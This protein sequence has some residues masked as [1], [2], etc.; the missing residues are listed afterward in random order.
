MSSSGKISETRAL[1]ATT[2]G[3]LLEVYDFVAYGIFA[4]P[5]SKAFFPADSESVSLLLTFL[6][7][8]SGFLVRPIGAL[9]LG[10]Y[11]DRCG[12]RKALSLTLGLMA[13]GTGILVI[14]PTYASIGMAAPMIVLAG[15]LIQG[16]SAGGEIGGAITLAIESV[17]PARRA[18]ASAVQQMAQGGGVLLTAL[19]GTA[20]SHFFTDAQVNDGA[21]RIVFAIGLLIVPVGI[22]IRR[23]LPETAPAIRHG[24]ASTGSL[25][26]L[27]QHAG[28]IVLCVAMMLFG[29]VAAYVSN[30]FATYTT[31]ELHMSMA[32]GYMG[33]LVYSTTVIISCPLLGLL[34]NRIGI[35]KL[36]LF[37][38]LGTAITTYPMLSY[39]AS[40]T[41][42]PTLAVVRFVT[43]ALSSCYL[44]C[45]GLALAEAFPRDFRATG[46]GF[47][48]AV[49]VTVF[50]G[51][52][53]AAV[54][55][56]ISLTGDRLVV[57]YYVAGAALISVCAV[58]ISMRKQGGRASAA[59]RAI[60]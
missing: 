9:V 24:T 42:F 17:S 23:A 33:Q 18:F 22:Y 39:L 55:A 1:V 27:L 35:F 50:G 38:A 2:V 59:A 25:R 14:C 21:W 58:L 6:T 29:T 40:H 37:G 57:A 54:T 43:A 60:G 15:R 3:N 48:Y 11:A 30:Y 19:A 7:F 44:A 46:I 16:F 20:L 49:G 4:V 41:D 26:G 28:S 5:I 45:L 13:V 52:T 47:S 10:R 31:H 8:A 32:D 12:R 56:L 34:A 51:F 36:M 53:P